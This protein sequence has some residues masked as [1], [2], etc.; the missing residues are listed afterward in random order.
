MF[1]KLTIAEV[2]NERL[3]MFDNHKAVITPEM[4]QR[5]MILVSNMEQQSKRS[6]TSCMILDLHLGMFTHVVSVHTDRLKYEMFNISLSNNWGFSNKI[7]HDKDIRSI[8][9]SELR[10][11]KRLMLL[12]PKQ[13][14]Q[15]VMITVR[16]IKN[17]SEGYDLYLIRCNVVECDDNGLPWLIEMEI[18]LL[19]HFVERVFTPMRQLFL[20][21]ECNNKIIKRFE[22]DNVDPLSKTER[23]VLILKCQNL[24]SN[25]DIGFA[26]NISMPTVKTHLQQ[27]REKLCAPSSDM[28]CTM[29][30]ML[31]MFE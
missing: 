14:K 1:A 13:Y 11:Y 7:Y 6:N 21:N 28:A 16:R 17:K 15:L 22:N 18:D 31:R 8:A 9:E 12:P 3:H 26:L 24:R 27:I 5:E 30:K 23:S 19:T 10:F 4:K 29:A 25:K 20:L 2:L